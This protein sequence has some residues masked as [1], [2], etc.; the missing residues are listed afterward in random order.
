MTTR[1]SYSSQTAKSTSD[2]EAKVKRF[3]VIAMPQSSLSFLVAFAVSAACLCTA[4]YVDEAGVFD[5][6]RENVGVPSFTS[7]SPNGKA[8]FVATQ[9]GVLAAISTKSGNVN[10]RRVLSEGTLMIVSRYL[11]GWRLI[12][13]PT[14]AATWSKQIRNSLACKFSLNFR[15]LPPSSSQ[16]S[17]SFR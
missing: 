17:S 13:A 15:P 11:L 9:A 2:H 1:G 3:G 12:F 8:L 5:W 6:K 4:M 14:C 16:S 7:Y 10:W